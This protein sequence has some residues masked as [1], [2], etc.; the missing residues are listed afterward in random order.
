MKHE[1]TDEELA[2]LKKIYDESGEAGLD[3]TEM[4]ALRMA[5]LLTNGLPS[6]PEEPS[7]RDL[8]L[9]HCKKRI[10][11]GQTFDGKE[12]AEALGMSQKTVGNILGQ[13]RKEGLLPAFDKHSPRKTTTTGKKKETMTTTQKLT[14]TN[15]TEEKL[16]PIGITAGT[17]SVRP[18]ATADPRAIISNALTGIFDAVSALQRTAF[19]ANDKVVYGFATKLLNGELMD[20]KANYSKDVAK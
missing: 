13:L 12:T 10:D 9:A 7:K 17:I 15:I 8:I 19:Q 2:E 4:R 16:T 1:Y 6:K 3:I 5:G 14:A 18:Q 20:L 11:Q